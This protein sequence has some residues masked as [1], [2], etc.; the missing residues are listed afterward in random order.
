M[1]RIPVLF[2][3]V[4]MLTQLPTSAEAAA[5]QSFLNA[6]KGI[7]VAITAQFKSPEGV[8][9]LSQRD[10]DTLIRLFDDPDPKVRQSAVKAFKSYVTR[11]SDY[12]RRVLRILDR[13][14]VVP[15]VKGEDLKTLSVVSNYS[16]V[17][18]KLLNVARYGNDDGLRA[19]AYKALYHSAASRSDVRDKLTYAARYEA[20]KEVRLGAIWG[21]FTASNNS[22]T[23]DRLAYLVRNDSD[24]DI[25]V[26]ALKSLYWAMGDN[27]L[28]RQVVGLARNNGTALRY[29]AI[30]ALSNPNARS[31]NEVENLLQRTARYD[32]DV[33]ARRL[34]IVAMGNYKTDEIVRHF[35]LILR[36][37]NGVP[38]N[39][40]LEFE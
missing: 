38:V 40:P 22:R 8:V 32:N 11:R 30:L 24:V 23:R 10:E 5:E 16:D 2:A 13:S 7:Q 3:A 17:Y 35:H 28:R 31:R 15:A 29:T 37:N 20:K 19:L 18:R 6:V 1:T 39:D 27:R 14:N 12:R 36:G 4:L 33:E 26:E 21:L 25:Q 34:A 9:A